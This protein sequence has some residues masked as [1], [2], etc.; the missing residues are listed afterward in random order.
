MNRARNE[1]MAEYTSHA[2][3]TPSWVDMMSPDIDASV[4]FY[5]T[6]F[7]WD[8][9]DQFDDDGNRIYV[10]FTVDGKAVAGL[11]GQPSEME[12][13]PAIWNTYI[14]TADVAATAAAVEVAGGSVMMPPM[15]VMTAGHMAI[16]TDPAGAAFSVWQPGEH[17]GAQI[18]NVPNTMCWN[19]LMTRDADAAM[20]F[21]TETFGW[22]YMAMDM[23][24]GTYNVIEGGTDDGGMGGIMAM[25]TEMPD[26][27]PNHWGVYFAVADIEATVEKAK[28]NGATIIQEP[29]A[30]PDIGT[31]AVIHDPNNGH[32]NLMQP[33][34]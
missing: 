18:G 15:Q 25:P 16:F 8:A 3:G 21:Y 17:I 34:G 26:E 12:G 29:F 11:G 14:T 4:K 30:I 31:V 19:E 1:V 6:L 10:M 27:V 32:F 22:N 5:T 24:V 33:Q 20:K 2:P 7:G 28:A 13:M 23:G 9:A